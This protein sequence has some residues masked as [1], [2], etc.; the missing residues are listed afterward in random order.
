MAAKRINVLATICTE[1]MNLLQ[2]V[3]M[4]PAKSDLSSL[5]LQ[6]IKLWYSVQNCGKRVNVSLI[7]LFEL[8]E[9]D[10]KQ[11]MD[12]CGSIMSMNNVKVCQIQTIDLLVGGSWS[13]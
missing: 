2:V 12:D 8:Q 9:K 3:I 10:L 4:C 11:Y 6:V 1:A 13:C 7:F 5:P